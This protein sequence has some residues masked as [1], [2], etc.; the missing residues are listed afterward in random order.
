MPGTEQIAGE[1]RRFLPH[2]A[3]VVLRPIFSGD[4]M[5]LTGLKI[6]G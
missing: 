5:R 4:V 6:K 1:D 2:H 3:Q